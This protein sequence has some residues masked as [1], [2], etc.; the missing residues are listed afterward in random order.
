MPAAVTPTVLW[1]SVQG[2]GSPTQYIDRSATIGTSDV[3]SVENAALA[4]VGSA[5]STSTVSRAFGATVRSCVMVAPLSSRYRS[6][7]VAGVVPG[8][9][10]R[11]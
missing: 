7:T 1:A 4:S 3:T 2:P 9:A 8:L 6:R 5:C 10:S 11:T